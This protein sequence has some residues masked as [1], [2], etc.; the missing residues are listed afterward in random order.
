M[1]G[2][3]TNPSNHSPMAGMAAVAEVEARNVHAL[4]DEP[5]D[6]IFR[7]ARRADGADDFRAPHV[8]NLNER[9]GKANGRWFLA[10]CGYRPLDADREKRYWSDQ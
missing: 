2:G 1:T 6:G 10:E 5:P 7:F 9:Q 8:I 3:A 4:R